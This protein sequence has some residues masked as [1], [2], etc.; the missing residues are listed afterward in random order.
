M[1]VCLY[2]RLFPL[3]TA[4]NEST[5]VPQ[6]KEVLGKIRTWEQTARAGERLALQVGGAATQRAEMLRD[7]VELLMAGMEKQNA[8]MEYLAMVSGVHQCVK[9]GVEGRSRH[10]SYRPSV[11]L[12]S[13]ACCC[14]LTLLDFLYRHRWLTMVMDGWASLQLIEPVLCR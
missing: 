5:H 7:A 14:W 1:F 3:C 6:A 11:K 10:R 12:C 8:R 13:F 2:V 9:F 4:I